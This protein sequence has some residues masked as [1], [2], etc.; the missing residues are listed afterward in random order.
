M[1]LSFLHQPFVGDLA[2]TLK[3]GIHVHVVLKDARIY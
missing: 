2:F 1:M 3:G